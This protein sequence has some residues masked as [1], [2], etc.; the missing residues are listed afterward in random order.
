[1]KRSYSRTVIIL[2]AGRASRFG[3]VKQLVDIGGEPL[4]LR[5]YRQAAQRDGDPIVMTT[6]EDIFELCSDHGCRVMRPIS[7]KTLL[8]TLWSSKEQWRSDT[9]ISLHGDVIFSK[10]CMDTIFLLKPFEWVCSFDRGGE[11][12]GIIFDRGQHGSKLLEAISNSQ[13]HNTCGSSWE[14]YAAVCNVPVNDGRIPAVGHLIVK[15]DTD[16]TC[17]LDYRTDYEEFRRTV[18]DAGRL[19]DLRKDV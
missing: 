7:N 12:F 19:D 8:H 2:A 11:T 4:I 17:D 1:M 15:P 3:S 18:I 6:D 5:T 10:A 16:Y 13:E 9:V 14:F